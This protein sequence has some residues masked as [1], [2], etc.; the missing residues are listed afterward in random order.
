MLLKGSNINI[1]VDDN[2]NL[3]FDF[4][5][6]KE[7]YSL[8]ILV[9]ENTKLHCL[10][11]LLDTIKLEKSPVII[12]INSGEEYKT[13]DTCL[14]IW[15]QLSSLN[16][17]RKALLI[18]LGG[19]V[20][21]DVGGFAAS[22]YKR[23]VDF[24]NIPTT[25]LAMVDASIGG[26]T[27]VNLDLYKNQI[28]LFSQ[29]KAVFINPQFLKTLPQHEL[30]NGYSEIIKHAL[31]K[32]RNYWNDIRLNGFYKLNDIILQ[33]VQI[34]NEIVTQDPHESGYRKIL[35]FGH[36]VGHAMEMLSEEI[37]NRQLSHGEAVAAGM[38]CECYISS[39]LSE[40]SEKE[41]TEIVHFIKSLF[42]FCKINKGH[43]QKIFDLM[44]FDK[45]NVNNKIKMVLLKS[46]GDAVIDVDVNKDVIYKAF[47]YY[48][49]LI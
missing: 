33:S 41:L 6:N 10:P 21:C 35:N 22:V 27:G 17:D 2:L 36:T 25:L 20:L 9:D 15:G 34:K 24:V 3:L 14:N 44:L 7:Q 39:L 16:A 18:N 37:F 30:I 4:L 31:V 28:G 1:Y 12:E 8:Y 11:F 29:P 45:K 19:G 46:I 49:K 42:S 43:Y 48:N 38:I 5:N 47:D 23:G 40:L 26:K 13:I 32:D